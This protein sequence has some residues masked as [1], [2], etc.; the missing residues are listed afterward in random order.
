M[1]IKYLLIIAIA[2][3]TVSCSTVYK[4]GQTPDDVYFSPAQDKQEYVVV[5]END[6]RMYGSRSQSLRHRNDIMLSVSYGNSFGPYYDPFYSSFY[7][8]INYNYPYSPF[9]KIGINSG[10]SYFNPYDQFYP[11]SWGYYYPYNYYGKDPFY[12]GYKVNTNTAPR[13]SNMGTYGNAPRMPIPQTIKGSDGKTYTP[14]NAPVRQFPNTSQSSNEQKSTGVGGFI[15]KIFT[16]SN[17][18]ESSNGRYENKNQP[19][20]TFEKERRE[21]NQPNRTFTPTLPPSSNNS[22]GSAPVRT[23][24]K[25]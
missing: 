11:Y 22:G 15:R 4:S 2:F 5:D 7:P 21:V 18:S 10:Y 9:M 24:R 16:P 25:N 1:K 23:F 14:Q 19:T 12:S 20:R 17:G 8:G 13:R 6:N 3:V